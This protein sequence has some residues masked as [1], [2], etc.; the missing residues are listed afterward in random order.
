VTSFLTF[1]GAARHAPQ[2]DQW[3]ESRPPELAVIARQWFQEMRAC[4]NDV[5]ELLHDGHP[6]ACVTDAA[7]GYVNV[8]PP[9]SHAALKALVQAACADIKAKM[10]AAA[11]SHG[12]NNAKRAYNVQST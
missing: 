10:P 7:F 2:I 12:G 11:S 3:F 4:G 1:N 6:T 9:T 5:T 8:F